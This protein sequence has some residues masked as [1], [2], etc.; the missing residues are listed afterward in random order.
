MSTKYDTLDGGDSRD[1]FSP[2]CW[3]CVHKTRTMQHTCAAFPARIPDAIWKGE[4][5]HVD[6]Y[7][8]DNGILFERRMPKKP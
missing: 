6:P 3:H 4:N 5:Y 7:P 8:G 2:V 1:F